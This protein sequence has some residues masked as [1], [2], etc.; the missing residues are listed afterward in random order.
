[1]NFEAMPELEL[2]WAYPVLLLLMLF[3]AV[4]C[5][6]LSRTDGSR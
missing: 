5:R 6:C 4:I 3:I 2:A 1:M